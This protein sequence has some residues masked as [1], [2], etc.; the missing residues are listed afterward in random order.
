MRFGCLLIHADGAE[1]GEG[2]P[3]GGG[4]STPKPD[5]QKARSLSAVAREKK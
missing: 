3:G 5:Q 2:T 4:V 1:D